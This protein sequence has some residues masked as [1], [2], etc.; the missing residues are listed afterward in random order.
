MFYFAYG[1]N[2]DPVQMA[3]RCPGATAVGAAQLADHRLCFPRRSPVRGCAVASIEPR[4][5]SNV[6]GVLYKIGRDD[7]VR[8]DEREGYDPVNLSAVN[9][10]D[11]VEITVTKSNGE[12]VTAMIYVAVPEPMPGLPSVTYLKHIVDGAVA[13]RLPDDYVARLRTFDVTEDA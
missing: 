11:R 7:L 2:L 9:R 10:Y 8:L 6:W 12:A 13:H 1:S 4:E 3:Q 5:G